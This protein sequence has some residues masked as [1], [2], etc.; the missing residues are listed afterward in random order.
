[1]ESRTYRILTEKQ[2]EVEKKL[3]RLEKKSQKYGIPFSYSFGEPRVY[4]VKHKD[5]HTGKVTENRYEVTDLTIDS[6]EIKKG[7]YTVLAYLEHGDKGNIV[8]TFQGDTVAEWVT[9]KAFCEHCN[10]N[11]GLKYTFMV[12][13]GNEIKQVGK[14][15]LKDYCGIDPQMIGIFNEFFE[16]LEENELNEFTCHFMPCVYDCEEALALAIMIQNEQ[17]Y[18]KSCERGSNKETLRKHFRDD[19]KPTDEIKAKA[20]EMVEAIK[21][22]SIDEA[23]KARLNNVQ[24][25]INADYCKDEDFGYF[26]YAPLAYENY[27]KHVEYTQKKEE[28]R[29]KMASAS[30]YVG[31]I[32]KREVFDVK[33]FKL[34]TS[35]PT[36]YGTSFLY[37][38]IDNN[39]NVL[40]WFTTSPMLDKE[41]KDITKVKKIKA[42]VKNHSERDG[43]KQTI[44]NRVVKVA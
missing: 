20:H 13:D 7:D 43:V 23:V 21:A 29:Q 12:S 1:M 9:R 25:R 31:E 32:G 6:E 35:F 8:N 42:T 41:Y 30:E 16:D 44:I 27:L 40:I 39:D 18:V 38:F 17:G 3:K 36:E 2:E 14:T 28:A 22:M 4:I 5:D 37:Q 11:H 10:S 34:V 15:C 19:V 26:A 24:V 33:E